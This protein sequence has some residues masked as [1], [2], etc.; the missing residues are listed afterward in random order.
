MSEYYK[1]PKNLNWCFDPKRKNNF[2]LSRSKLDLF[3]SCPRC[4]YVDNR[5]GVSRPPGY[6]FSLNSAVDALFKKEFD[7]HR[8]DKTKHPLMESYGIDAVPFQHEKMDEWRDAL[9]RGIKYFHEKTGLVVKG[10]IDD[11]WVNPKGELIIVDYK[12]TSKNSEVN[13]DA[14]W[15]ICYK[16][17]I[18]IYQWLFRQ[19]GFK[20]SNVGY[21][22]YAN[23]I[24]DKKAFDAKLEFDIS[25]IPYKGDDS[26]VEQAVI[27]AHKCLM[28]DKLPQADDDC[29]YCRYRKAVMDVLE[30]R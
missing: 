7:I 23:G 24:T 25:I 8:S 10:G 11:I 5:L 20:V 21:F 9:R 12:S 19:N 30:V 13:I 15:Q 6:P 22:V 29:D 27:D 2:E 4:F 17:Q 18:E 28:S 3:L 16:R 1:V 14:N 26:W